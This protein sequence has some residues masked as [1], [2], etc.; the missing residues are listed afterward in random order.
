MNAPAS[1]ARFGVPRRARRTRQ[2]VNQRVPEC[3][4]SGHVEKELLA[5]EHGKT[6]VEERTTDSIA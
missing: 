6:N 1:L 2:R 5:A 3:R 4:K